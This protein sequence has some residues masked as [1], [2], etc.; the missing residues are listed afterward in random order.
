MGFMTYTEEMRQFIQ[1]NYKDISTA[2]LTER[3]NVEFGTNLCRDTMKKYKENHG[4][5][6]GRR[7]GY[8]IIR[9]TEEMHEF[10][11]EFVPGHTHREIQ[12][13]F[14][15]RF[16]DVHISVNKVSSYIKNHNLST[17]F[18]GR[19]V[20]GNV[21]AN[22]GKKMS[23]E[24]YE[25]CKPTMFKKGQEPI[26]HRPIGSERI[27][28]DGYIEVKIAEPNKW[29][30]KHLIVWEEVNGPVPPK[31][32][33]FFMDN[34]RTN[35]VLENLRCIPRSQ[36]VCMN[37]RCGFQGYDRESNEVALTAA[38]LTQKIEQIKR[39]GR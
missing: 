17:G 6:N 29:R 16:P 24:M 35:V 23:T 38:E 39:G 5:K 1:D 9:Y 34:D 37:G 8:S 28:K 19:F 3:F 36:L 4:L 13:E 12:A 32:C 18:T 22:K 30:L 14:N 26:N 20:K 33:I 31:H 27:T 21:P 10:M 2:E 25:K 7:G 11:R 15:K